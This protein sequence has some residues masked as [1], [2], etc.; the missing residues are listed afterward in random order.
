MVTVAASAPAKT[1]SYMDE[2]IRIAVGEAN[3]HRSL[4]AWADVTTDPEL[5]CTLR[6]V[7]ARE[8]NHAQ[9]FKQ[10]VAELGGEVCCTPDRAAYARLAVA[11]NPA[12]SDAD[13]IVPLGDND[14]P[15]ASIKRRLAEGVYDACTANHMSWWI[16]E[17]CDSLARLR[18]AYA[19][20]LAK[21]KGDETE[22]CTNGCAAG[23]PSPD[24]QAI[25]A[26]MTEGFGRLEKS[27]EKLAR[28]A[29]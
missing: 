29:K 20:V 22:A 27:I 6:L 7:A 19:A 9:V 23:E 1:I 12:L 2:L 5:A 26:C 8:A 15:F 17:E 18:A 16:A 28:G 24:A 13:K 3:A 11:A 10:L 4:T 14:D 21:A 25:M